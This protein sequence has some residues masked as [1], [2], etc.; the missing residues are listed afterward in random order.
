MRTFG[1]LLKYEFLNI[2]RNRWVFVLAAG[3]FAVTYALIRIAGDFVKS[4]LSLSSVIV[5]VVP[6]IAT[7]FSVVYW[8]YS[9][10]FT[11]LLLTQP[12]LRRQLLLARWLALGA[13]LTAA[14]GIGIVLPFA[15]FDGVDQG[16]LFIFLTTAFLA[17][18]FVTLGIWIAS[19]RVDRMKGIGLALTLWFYFAAIHDALSLLIL[20]GLREYPLDP[21]AATLGILNPIGLIRVLHLMRY[22]APLLLSYSGAFV[23]NVLTGGVGMTMVIGV[24]LLWLSVPILLAKRKFEGRDF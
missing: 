5:I 24:G 6:L 12:I 17:M 7:L 1:K 3:L 15:L 14:M 2:V 22:E 16:V 19:G 9:E 20:L 8:Y 10:R 4:I 13:S 11:E 21:V 23:R 18:V